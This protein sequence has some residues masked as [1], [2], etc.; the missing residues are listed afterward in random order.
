MRLGFVTAAAALLATVA[1]AA[2]D[3]AAHGWFQQAVTVDKTQLISILVA[4]SHETTK[5]ETTVSAIVVPWR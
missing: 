2:T 3:P 4:L 1:A 5:L